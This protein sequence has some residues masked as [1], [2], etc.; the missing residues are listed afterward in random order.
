MARYSHSQEK[1]HYDSL[2]SF[3]KYGLTLI[4][5]LI[6]LVG[7]FVGFITYSNGKEMRD[8]LASE[9]QMMHDNVKEMKDELKERE[10]SMLKKERLLEERVTNQ[11][12]NS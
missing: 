3:L 10:K 2:T 5:T 4:T 9:K 8:A 11:L 6:T 7:L 12:E 1:Q